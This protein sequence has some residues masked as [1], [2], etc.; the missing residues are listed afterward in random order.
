MSKQFCF[1]QF[2]LEKIQF[3]FVYERPDEGLKTKPFKVG[4]YFY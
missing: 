4:N 3:F 2:S 1:K